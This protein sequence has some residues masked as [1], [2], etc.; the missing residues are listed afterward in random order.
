MNIGPDFGKD[1]PPAAK[2]LKAEGKVI[3]AFGN[4]KVDLISQLESS[5]GQ[6][7]KTQIEKDGVSVF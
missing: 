7:L 5:K 6:K 2:L 4:T 3:E 1:R